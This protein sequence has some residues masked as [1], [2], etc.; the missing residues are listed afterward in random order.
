[1]LLPGQLG[2]PISKNVS[3]IY[4]GDE[5]PGPLHRD[6]QRCQVGVASRFRR[7]RQRLEYAVDD[8]TMFEAG[9][10]SKPVFAYAVMKLCER[11]TL[12]L[13]TP[14]NKYTSDL[15]FGVTQG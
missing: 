1:M 15:S 9:S 10:M 8:S 13:D 6:H 7:H 2:L 14:L 5:S 12:K 4:G 3:E 11:G